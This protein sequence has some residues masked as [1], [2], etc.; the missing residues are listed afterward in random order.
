MLIEQE[1]LIYKRIAKRINYANHDD[2]K[3]HNVV[4][5]ILMSSGVY[6]GHNALFLLCLRRIGIPYIKVYGKSKKGGLHCW[7]IV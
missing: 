4:G 3:D 1:A 6:E 7:T 5:P 2:A